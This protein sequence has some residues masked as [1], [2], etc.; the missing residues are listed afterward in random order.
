MSKALVALSVLGLE[1]V[2]HYD[3]RPAASRQP[4]SAVERR[5]SELHA[6][7]T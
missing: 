1:M 2:A 7:S 3:L 5:I 6:W 4:R